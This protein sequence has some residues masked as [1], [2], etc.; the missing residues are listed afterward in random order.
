ME[1]HCVEG[2]LAYNVLYLTRIVVR[3]L[4]GNSEGYQ[5]VGEYRMPLV[6]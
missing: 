5:K 3:Y 1:S 6:H 4:G 2:F